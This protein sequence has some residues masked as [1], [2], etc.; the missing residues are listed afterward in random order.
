[1]GTSQQ[2]MVDAAFAAVLDALRERPDEVVA[3][4]GKFSAEFGPGSANALLDRVEQ[5]LGYRLPAAIREAA[6]AVKLVG[7]G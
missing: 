1:M 4:V 5:R 3:A 2:Q 7:H 6:S